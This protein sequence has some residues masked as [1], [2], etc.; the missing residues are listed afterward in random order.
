M[1]ISSADIQK[2]RQDTGLGVMDCKK[3]LTDAE[4]DYDKALEIARKAG[5]KVAAK[6]ADREAGQGLIDAYIHPGSQMGVLIQVNCETDFVARNEEFK[7]MVHDLAMHIAAFNPLYITPEDV[8]EDTVEKEKEIYKEQLL[9][10]G[11]PEKML[12]KIVEGKLQKYFEEVCLL[13]QP[14]LKNE[15]QTIKEFV[16]EKIGKIGENINIKRFERFSLQ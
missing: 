13:N 14:Y 10:E 16:E 15:N 4:G 6:K 3:F 1:A 11:K 5:E 7:E 2:L 12:D 9:N 8:P